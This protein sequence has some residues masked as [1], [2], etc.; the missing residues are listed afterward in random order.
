MVVSD[1]SI[2]RNGEKRVV[3][4]PVSWTR[5]DSLTRSDHNRSLQISRGF[6]ERIHFFTGNG[7]AATSEPSKDVFR[8]SVF[9]QSRARTHIQPGRVAWQPSLANRNELCISLCRLLDEIERLCNAG[10]FVQLNLT[11][12]RPVYA[13]SLPIASPPSPLPHT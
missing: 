4:R 12:P 5:I 2:F 1:L 9:P 10:S 11:P 3:E 6:T 7:D 13:H 8:R